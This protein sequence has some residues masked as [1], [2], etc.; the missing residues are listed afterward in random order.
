MGE[1][2]T[3]GGSINNFK[4]ISFERN[5]NRT[6]LVILPHHEFDFEA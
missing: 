3:T 5:L 1:S 6:T 4:S 2:T